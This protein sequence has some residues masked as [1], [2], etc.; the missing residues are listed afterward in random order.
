MEFLST[1]RSTLR[2]SPRRAE[3]FPVQA[4]HIERSLILS[5]DDDPARP[6]QRL[7]SL[8][9]RLIPAA[10]AIDLTHVSDRL[11]GGARYPDV[12]PGEHYKLLAALVQLERPL[13][14]IE[15]GTAQGLSALALAANLPEGGQVVTFDIVPWHEIAETCLRPGDMDTNQIVPLIGDLSDQAVFAEHENCLATADLI[16]VDAPKDGRFE[17]LFLRHLANVSFRKPVLVVLDDIRVWNMLAVW[18]GISRP[19]LD[20]TSFGHWSGTGLIDWTASR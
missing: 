6:S 5:A 16:F 11:R 9:A 13:G 3:T 2:G 1:I 14:I 7:L 20:I 15:I 12:W 4:R 17:P 18:R 19:K 10:A 8:A